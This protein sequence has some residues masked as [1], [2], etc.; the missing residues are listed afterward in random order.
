MSGSM[1]GDRKRGAAAC[2]V[3]APILDSTLGNL[4]AAL[5]AGIEGKA[6]IGWRLP[7]NRDFRDYEHAP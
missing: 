4:P 6:N 2:Q 5:T 1:S 7:N 3:T